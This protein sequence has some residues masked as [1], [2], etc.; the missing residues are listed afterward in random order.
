MADNLSPELRSLTMSRVRGKNT[1]LEMRVR[2]LV[3]RAGF[4]Y[5]LHRRDLPGTPDMTFPS[6]SKVIFVHGCFWHQHDCGSRTRP[7]TNKD[8]WDRKLDHN[9]QKDKK[10]ISI[11]KKLGWAVLVV[12][13]C[14]TRDAEALEY[15][16]KSFLEP[17][18]PQIRNPGNQ[19]SSP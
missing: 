6:L 4:R 13:E 9:I 1:R 16:I 10:N 14:E 7:N 8:F 12:W 15:R 17:S 2:R 5:R 19:K 3:H 18:K 11:L